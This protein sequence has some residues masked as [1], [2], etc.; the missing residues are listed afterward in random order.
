MVSV[1]VRQLVPVWPA[2]VKAKL[3]LWVW[4]LPPEK[5][6]QLALLATVH[7]HALVVVTVVLPVPPAATTLCDVIGRASRRLT[8]WI[9][10]VA[11]PAKISEPVRELVPVLAATLNATVA[12][13]GR[14]LL[15]VKVMLLG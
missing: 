3:P 1:R 4:R 6:I 7:A 10:V 2:T 9:S 11:L 8:A 12:L 14:L 13:P 15:S 5:V